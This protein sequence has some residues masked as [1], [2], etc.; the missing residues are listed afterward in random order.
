MGLFERKIR[1][2]YVA[3]PAE[4]PADDERIARLNAAIWEAYRDGDLAH[5]DRL[6]DQRNAI[7]P[8]NRVGSIID[9]RRENP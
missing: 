4:L 6:L 2:A 5:A 8:A 9:N 1:P 7:R 3:A